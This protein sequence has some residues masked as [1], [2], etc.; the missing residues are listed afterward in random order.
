MACVCIPS[1]RASCKI[2]EGK[3]YQEQ[4]VPYELLKDLQ[5]WIVLGIRER[6]PKK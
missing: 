5:G 1:E 3:G 6:P 2:C 4:W